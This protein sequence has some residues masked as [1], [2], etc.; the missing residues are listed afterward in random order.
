MHQEIDAHQLN[1][2]VYEYGQN[3]LAGLHHPETL[4]VG[5]PLIGNKTELLKALDALLD[6]YQDAP[7][8]EPSFRLNNKLIRP[9]SLMSYLDLI[10]VRMNEPDVPLWQFAMRLKLT[11]RAER[12]SK[13]KR[14]PDAY[15]CELLGKE[16]STLYR[17]ARLNSESAARGSFPTPLDIE[18]TAYPEE[19]ANGHLGIVWDAYYREE[20]R[21]AE[22]GQT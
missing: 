6:G 19:T 22:L 10:W 7:R 9:K 20:S 2:C 18:L 15:E 12:I 17:K 3:V 1:Q 21:L 14:D 16:V 4:I 8:P 11:A 5:L 13:A